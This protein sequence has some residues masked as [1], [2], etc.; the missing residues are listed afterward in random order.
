M[1]ATVVGLDPRELEAELV[2]AI[3]RAAVAERLGGAP[4]Q[5]P[6]R[7]WLSVHAATFV[8]IHV[9]GRLHGC[10]GTVEPRRKLADDLRHNGVLAAFE[11]PR[12]RALRRD[13]LEL[14]RF[15]VAILGP[16]VPLSFT[17][18]ADARARLRPR[19]DGVILSWHGYRGLFLPKVWESLP[20][21][22]AFLA[23]LK[24]KAGLSS[25]FWRHD[26]VLERFEVLEFDE[27]N[28]QGQTKRDP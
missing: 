2:L 9:D 19:I 10:I 8:S 13:E 26:V 5:V 17:D 20:E 18:E 21:P 27:P 24:R 6:A 22:S 7:P 3:A 12:S 16:R 11:D 28:D 25:D 14:S 15:C 4:M 23:N 1:S